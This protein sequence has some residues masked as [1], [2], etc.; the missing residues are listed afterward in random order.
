MHI[1]NKYLMI[2]SLST[3]NNIFDFLKP[4]NLNRPIGHQSIID[5]FPLEIEYQ[6][7]LRGL[8]HHTHTHTHPSSSSARVLFYT[9]KHIFIPYL[10]LL[11]TYENGK[12]HFMPSTPQPSSVNFPKRRRRRRVVRPIQMTTMTVTLPSSPSDPS[13]TLQLLLLRDA[14]RW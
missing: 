7:S 5:H 1:V 12:I 6:I 3:L 11:R 4:I 2:T 8:Y 14:M 10:I 9:V 13:H